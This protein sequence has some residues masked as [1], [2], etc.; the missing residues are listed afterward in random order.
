[1]Q[2]VHDTYKFY[3]P[4]LEGVNITIRE[5][6][7]HSENVTVTLEWSQENPSYS[8]N[9][10]VIPQIEL[11]YNHQCTTCTVQLTLSY[12]TQYNA[13]VVAIHPC[14]QSTLTSFI[15]L[16]YSECCNT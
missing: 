7:L 10:T 6:E 1:M 14:G 12:N 2:S 4:G 13:S 9:V 3:I 15:E 11:A 5:V 16:Y 8:Y